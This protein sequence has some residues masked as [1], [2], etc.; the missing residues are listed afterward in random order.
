[1]NP[2]L[3]LSPFPAAPSSLADAVKAWYCVRVMARR[4][5][6]AALNL[7]QRTGVPV[8]SP[9]I[10]VQKKSPRPEP[11]FS[12]EALF[13]GYVFA[14]FNYPQDARYVASTP[15]VLGLVSF[16][17]NPPAIADSVIDQLSAEVKREAL[18]PAVPLFE[19]GAWV[20]I[21]AGCFQGSEGRVLQV[22]A[23]ST[24][25]SVLL[26]LLGQ[27]IQVSMPGSQLA[28]T[29]GSCGKFP[30]GLRAIE[31]PAGNRR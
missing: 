13:P 9:R 27:E 21:I 10:K 4:E 3:S 12:T 2:A 8:F 26:N 18:A 22:S 17:G 23:T 31:D 6:I 5:H 28:G 11:C 7:T 30:A 16:G 14:R 15:G 1:M 19:E 29:D 25:I 20:R 24:R